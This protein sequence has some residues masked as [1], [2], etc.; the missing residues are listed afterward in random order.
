M[1]LPYMLVLYK[2]MSFIILFLI[3]TP[4][5]F[6]KNNQYMVLKHDEQ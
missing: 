4:S 1:C 3:L 5:H 2:Y 6:S